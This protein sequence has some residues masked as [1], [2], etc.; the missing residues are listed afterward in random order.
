MYSYVI[1]VQYVLLSGRQRGNNMVALEGVRSW[2]TFY[3]LTKL[4]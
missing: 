1:G 3:P 4:F 2:L